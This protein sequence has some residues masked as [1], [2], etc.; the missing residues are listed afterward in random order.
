MPE[1]PGKYDVLCTIAREAAG[2]QGAILI[3]INGRSG[4][5]FSAQLPPDSVGAVVEMLRSVA[6][7]IERDA[8][9]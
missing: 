5:G 7:E 3:V 6:D 1:G 8:T 9:T 4:S 2:A